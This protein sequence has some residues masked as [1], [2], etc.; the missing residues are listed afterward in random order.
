MSLGALGSGGG[1]CDRHTMTSNPPAPTPTSSAVA[2]AIEWRS[3]RG[4]RSA[5]TWLL[6][7]SA[8]TTIAVGL[9]VTHH[10]SVVDDYNRSRVSYAATQ[11]A[12][13]IVGVAAIAFFAM[14]V[15]TSVV[16]IVWMW[17]GVK[18]NEALGRIRPRYTSG[19]S[20]GGWFIPIG[21][22]WI[23]V[24]IM[25][26]L[27]E[28]SDPAVSNFQDWRRAPRSALV[29][30]WWGFYLASRVLTVTPVGIV[31]SIPAAI[32]AILVVRSITD[33]QEIAREEQRA[34]H[35]APATSGWYADPTGRFDHRYWNGSAWT[36]HAAR[37]GETVVDPLG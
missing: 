1:Q 34:R 5:L 8:V 17:R 25:Q 3:T 24:R 15:A 27:W 12:S 30:W 14:L 35:L 2:P 36:L 10:N 37:A 13:R 29:G 6:T 31:C 18:N 26:D 11:D 7:A 32:L 23:P 22:L 16:F 21:N 19:W 4:L 33:R 28:G 9:A 20:I